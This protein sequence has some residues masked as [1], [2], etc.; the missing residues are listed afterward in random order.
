MAD[1]PWQANLTL[2]VLSKA[3]NLAELWG[4]RP[5]NSNPCRK[6][7]RYPENARE[8]FLASDELARLGRVFREAGYPGL[9]WREREG[10][11]AKHRAKEGDRFTPISPRALAAIRLLLFTGARLSEILELKWEHV[12][13][14]RAT[15]TLPS[16][17]G[18]A[19]RAHSVSS[20]VLAI[21]NEIAREEGSPWVLPAPSEYL[22]KSVVE[23]AWQRIHDHAGILD[24]RI[25]DLRHTVGT[26]ASQ[27]GVNAFLV[28]DLL[29][30]SNVAVTARYAN[31]DEDPIRRVSEDVSARISSGLAE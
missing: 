7:P 27:T 28:R 13:F 10:A 20:N 2:A 9:P 26:L 25:H 14:E 6:A 22:S 16:H 29:R 8:R 4:M 24:V 3:F 12:D 23:N 19:R 5:E 15:I 1:T 11:S 17:K 30:H 18:G 31:R 21:V